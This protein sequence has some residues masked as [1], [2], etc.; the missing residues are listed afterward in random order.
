M[1][2]LKSLI[3]SGVQFGHQS[4]RWNPKM[5]PFI[6]GQKN[7]IHLIDVSKTAFQ[8]EKASKF[9]EGLA[10]EGK[11]I[12]WCG[13][14]KSAQIVLP[15]VLEKVNCPS[16]T[17]RWIGGTLTNFPQIKKSVTKMLHYGD[18]LEKA[19]DSH[20]VKK[21]LNRMQKL[22][23]RLEKNVGGIRELRWPIG[24][25][26]VVDVKK[27]HV[28]V[29]EAKSAGIPIVALVDTNSDPVGISY[30][31]PTNDDAP[32]A[33]EVI[34]D[35]LA[36]AVKRGQAVA[37][38]TAMTREAEGFAQENTLEKMLETV[39]RDDEASSARKRADSSRRP[40]ARRSGPARPAR[41]T[42]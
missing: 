8:L 25:L 19:D 33:I 27:E 11:S 32:R 38:E 2:D 30:V 29:K 13:T 6:W 18:V 9:L 4:W 34:L 39:L 5:K 31:I 26:V 28:A 16:V 15:K 36:E 14:K 3:K 41:R 12:L 17:H 10:A 7:G 1:I 35:Y 40:A 42:S 20:Y 21:E 37:A 22:R 23:E 24:A